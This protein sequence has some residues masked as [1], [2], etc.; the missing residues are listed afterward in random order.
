M[1]STPLSVRYYT[2]KLLYII[3]VSGTEPWQVALCTAHKYI[4]INIY[5]YTNILQSTST[6][7]YNAASRRVVD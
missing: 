5:T 3:Y 2:L 7:T 6:P 4:Y 1:Q